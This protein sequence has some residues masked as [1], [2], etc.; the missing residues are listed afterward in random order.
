MH[1]S[2]IKVSM[3]NLGYDYPCT[4]HIPVDTENKYIDILH[5]STAQKERMATPGY[6]TMGPDGKVIGEL[7]ELRG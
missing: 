1:F 7:Y 3:S 2:G 4:V 5:K 6:M